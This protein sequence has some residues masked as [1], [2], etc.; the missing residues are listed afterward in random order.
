[1]RVRESC[2]PLTI[3]VL[4]IVAETQA[5]PAQQSVVDQGGFQM[6]TSENFGEW[7]ND[8]ENLEQMA[9]YVKR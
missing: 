9:K 1:M 6:P 2:T 4:R 5:A 8:E 3:A 7:M